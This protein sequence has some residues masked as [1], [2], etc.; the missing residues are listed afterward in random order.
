MSRRPSSV[1]LLAAAALLLGSAWPARA[2]DAPTGMPACDAYLAAYERCLRSPGVPESVRPDLL[3]NI[4][5]LRK[6]WQGMAA[7]DARARQG[8]EAQCLQTH[9]T[10]RPQL[11]SAFKCDFPAPAG[12]PAQNAAAAE[13]DTIL[14][15]NAYTGVQNTIVRFHPFARQLADYKRDN[16]RVLRLGTKL[17]ANAWYAFGI[18]DLDNVLPELEKAVAMPGAVP[19]VDEPAAALLAALRELNPTIKALDRYQ[20]TRA[21]QDDKFAFAREQHPVLVSRME[22]AVRTAEAFDTALFDRELA[23]DEKRLASLTGDSPARALLVTSLAARRTVRQFEALAP[24]ADT[25][26]FQAS[27]AALSSASR[28]LGGVLDAMTPPAHYG[29]TGYLRSIDELIGY[30][31]DVARDIAR[32]GNPT[33]PAEQFVTS[34]NRSV[35]NLSTCTTD[36]ARAKS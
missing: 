7:R 32:G 11:V 30:G 29:C 28:S 17:G 4:A 16:E 14:K 24:K 22:G 2:S 15:A 8:I 10:V 12:T 6:T 18:G 9:Q 13:Q 36:E 5:D 23:R 1:P 3:G 26:A 25:A 19:G 35:E 21:F 34:Y 20:T 27:L 33:N 31:R